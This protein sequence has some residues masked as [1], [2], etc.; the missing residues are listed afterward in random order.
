MTQAASEGFVLRNHTFFS[1]QILQYSAPSHPATFGQFPLFCSGMGSWKT[2][3]KHRFRIRSGNKEKGFITQKKKKIKLCNLKYKAM[4]KCTFYFQT[5]NSWGIWYTVK[6]KHCY[7]KFSSRKWRSLAQSVKYA[8]HV[9][10]TFLFWGYFGV[11]LL[12][13][14]CYLV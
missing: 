12:F 5:K 10:F 2:S 9:I 11:S 3:L 6:F 4:K 1:P 7:R 13:Q 8:G 14:L